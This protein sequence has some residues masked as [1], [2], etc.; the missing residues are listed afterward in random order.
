[1]GQEDLMGPEDLPGHHCRRGLLHRGALAILAPPA[2]LA[3][4]KSRSPLGGFHC[5]LS[6]KPHT[7]LDG[8]A[9]ERQTGRSGQLAFCISRLR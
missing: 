8:R 2:G 5:L 3:G 4:H 9:D 1:M 6:D 7:W